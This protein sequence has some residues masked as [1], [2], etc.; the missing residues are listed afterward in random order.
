VLQ[1]FSE[2][3]LL[4]LVG[5][6]PDGPLGGLALTLILSLAG[7]VLSFPLSVIL[8]LCRSGN[9]RALRWIATI[10]V[11]AI[12]GT[13][14]VM[15]VFWSYFL[16]PTLIGH[17]VSGVTTLIC[18]LIVYEAAYLSEVVRAGIESLPKGQQEASRALGL[19]YWRTNTY[20]VLPQALFNMIPSIITQFVSTIKD[21][22]IGYV[23]SVQ[24]VT[25]SANTVNNSLLTKPFQV[26]AI[27]ALIYFCV[28]FTLTQFAQFYERRVTSK[29]SRVKVEQ[30]SVANDSVLEGQ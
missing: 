18:T 9:I 20:V 1:I 26:F 12:R 28:C 23:I 6:Y 25:F 19:G 11:Y 30:R 8:A 27:L 3:W 14:I 16:V 5:Q 22:S 24:E 2:N 15:L 10:I 7:L 13:P 29:R 17:S 4:F 21:T